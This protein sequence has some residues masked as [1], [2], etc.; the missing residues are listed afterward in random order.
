MEDSL[1][2]DLI[3]TDPLRGAQRSGKVEFR[4]QTV[5][6]SVDVYWGS[7]HP[8]GG[9]ENQCVDESIYFDIRFQAAINSIK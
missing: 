1:R 4:C 9:K 8:I 5:P 3:P 7:C 6:T 2:R